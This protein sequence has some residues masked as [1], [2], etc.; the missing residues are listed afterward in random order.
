[1]QSHF[2]GRLPSDYISLTALPRAPAPAAWGGATSRWWLLEL[3]QEQLSAA[4]QKC[5]ASRPA[6]GADNVF[7][8]CVEE[9]SE[10]VIGQTGVCEIQMSATL[11]SMAFLPA[12]Y[13]GVWVSLTAWCRP[14]LVVKCS[15]LSIV[16]FQ[17][18]D[19]AYFVILLSLSFLF[20]EM[21]M[22]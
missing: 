3:P 4:R 10:S 14:L 22:D 21:E 17:G 19:L 5:C 6:P 16:T 20:Y 2:L 7:D 8:L 15:K 12:E 13:P 9:T 11:L 18:H 1:M